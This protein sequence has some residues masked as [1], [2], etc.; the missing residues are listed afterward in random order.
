M[1]PPPALLLHLTVGLLLVCGSVIATQPEQAD[2][3][4]IQQYSAAPGEGPAVSRVA[5]SLASQQFDSGQQ[6]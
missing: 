3:R 1:Q 5:P 6:P 2:A 4:Q